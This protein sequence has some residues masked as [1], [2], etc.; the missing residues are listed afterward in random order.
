MRRLAVVLVLMFAPACGRATENDAGEP[1]C[2]TTSTPGSAAT[3]TV[4]P[5]CVER[6]T[7]T[8][9]GDD[10]AGQV[11]KGTVVQVYQFFCTSR[12]RSPVEFTPGGD[13]RFETTIAFT[14]VGTDCPIPTANLWSSQP[15]TGR[16]TENR[17][18]IEG[19]P[20]LTG[21]V[22]RSGNRITGT[23]KNSSPA[24][25]NQTYTTS[26]ELRCE[27]GCG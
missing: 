2:P 27:T 7:E 6:A 11:W 15:V 20:T 24:D 12:A 14:E 8:N 5:R 1:D 18:E 4:D 16:L 22:D 17:L 9:R 13:G 26:W 3:T 25:P 19:A 23:Y 10:A 21:T